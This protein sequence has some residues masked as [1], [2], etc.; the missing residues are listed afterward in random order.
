M[1]ASFPGHWEGD[2]IKGA[3]N[4]SAV[5][6]LVER[7]TLFVTLARVNDASAKAAVTG[8]SKVLNRIDAQRRLSMTYD[9]GCEMSQH[10][11]LSEMTGVNIYFADPHSPWQRG[12][13][14]NTSGLLRQ[15]MSKGTDLSMF[16]AFDTN[17]FKV[18]QK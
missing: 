4:A 17:L 9:Q 7:T 11:R 1:T 2:L 15:Y 5:G 3:R 16:T 8:F 13:T 10:E 14:E 6:T 12:I 18:I